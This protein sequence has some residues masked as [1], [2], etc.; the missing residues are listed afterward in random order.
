MFVRFRR[1]T[2]RLQ[3]SLVETRRDGSKE[4]HEHVANL[5]AVPLAAEVADRVEFWQRLFERLPIKFR[6]PLKR[7]A[8]PSRG[9][10]LSTDLEG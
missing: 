2:R 10:A 9:Q 8:F 7:L 4:R 1:S 3:L 5:G 6:P